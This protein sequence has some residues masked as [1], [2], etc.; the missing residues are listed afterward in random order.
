[1]NSNVGMNGNY[2]EPDITQNVDYLGD[3]DWLLP[4]S[5]TVTGGYGDDWTITDEDGLPYHVWTAE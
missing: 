2:E 3:G 5:W 4:D 1:M